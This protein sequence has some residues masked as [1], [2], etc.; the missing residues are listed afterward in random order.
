MIKTEDNECVP[1]QTFSQ[2]VLRT[3]WIESLCHKKGIQMTRSRRLV[4]QILEEAQDHPDVRTIFQRAFAQD[5]SIS[6]PTV[7]RTVKLFEG[8]GALTKHHF[9]DGQ[10]R[11]ELA[12]KECHDHLVDI[13]SGEVVEF[14]GLGLEELKRSIEK[15]LGYTIVAH[16]LDFYGV[17]KSKNISGCDV[18]RSDSSKKNK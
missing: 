6:M 16:R 2:P 17:R 15:R 18:A 12:S 4:A 8:L 11:Y 5:A 10:A 1:L 9:G 3:S 14:Q 13:D 7:Y